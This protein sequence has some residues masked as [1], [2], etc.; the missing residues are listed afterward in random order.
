MTAG[1]Y[2]ELTADEQEIVLA[3][4]GDDYQLDRAAKALHRLTMLARPTREPAGML[5]LPCSWAAV[6][7]L[8]FTFSSDS[9]GRWLPQARLRAWITAE[10]LRR[11]QSRAYPADVLIPAGL[12][13]RPYQYEAASMI[14]AAGKFLLF[15]DP[16]PQPLSARV[17][18][19]S[20]WT[21][22]GAI[23]P[24]DEVIGTDGLPHHV[25]K[26]YDKGVRPVYEI[27]FSDGA[28]TRASADHNWAVRTYQMQAGTSDKH[29]VNNRA[30]EYRLS[31]GQRWLVKKTSELKSSGSLVNFIPVASPV[32]FAKQELP[33]H[34]YVLGALLGNG[35]LSHGVPKDGLVQFTTSREEFA[36][37]VG[38][39]TEIRK[40]GNGLQWGVHA[41]KEVHALGLAGK[42]SREKFIPDSYL[43]G[44]REQREDL[45]N[46]LMD[47]DG[48]V[49]VRPGRRTRLQW[50]TTSP[51]LRNQFT[52][53]VRSLGGTARVMHEDERKASTCWTLSLELPPEVRPFQVSYKA[54]PA[55][56]ARTEPAR[57]VHS[58]EPA[59]SE[60][61]KCLL[62]DAPDHLYITDNYVVTSNCGKTVSTLLGLKARQLTH[63]LFPMLI[64]VPSWDVGDVW[65]R[66]IKEWAPD[67]PEP[68]MYGGSNRSLFDLSGINI[69]TYAT[70][71]IDAAD[72]RGPLVKLKPKAVVL[73]EAHYCRNEKALRTH[74]V[75]RVAAH[76]GTFVG[77]T[78]TPVTKDTGDIYP[79]LAAMDP[80]SYPA[81]KRFVDRY[82]DTSTNGYEESIDGLKALAEPEFRT[83]LQGQYRRVAKADVLPQLPPKIYSVR[84]VELPAEWQRAYDSMEQDMLAEL[85]GDGGQLPVMS[86]LAQLTRLGQL[87]SSACDV[88]VRT[89]LDEYGAE[90]KHYDVTLKAP[91]WKADAL[92][93]VLAERK[94]QQVA[95]FANS[96][97]LVMIAEQACAKAG[98]SCGLI[99]GGQPK[100]AR[101][102]DIGQ[103]QAGE[104]D[105]ILATAGAGALGITLTAA[106]TAVMLQ[107][108]WEFDKALQPEDRLSRLDD[109]V[110]KHDCL[111]IIDIVAKGTIDQRVRELTRSKGMQLGQLVQD[112]RLVRELLGGL[113]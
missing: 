31:R 76:A 30:H 39:Y 40:R 83:V 56:S 2:A 70:L 16:G 48:R 24:G 23:Q 14:A 6:T 41:G 8:A 62:V 111:E 58:V 88:A 75:Q 11:H 35:G 52:E 55:Q 95:V 69:T 21:T 33:L 46:G 15:D 113:K 80:A 99:T 87:A 51:V 85:P 47:S 109:I 27:T 92:L 91:S 86:V 5:T 12:T 107:R 81:R 3:V 68:S 13:P 78:G 71:R 73:D 57:A 97:Q 101:Q 59:G 102:Q 66:H 96:K 1:I 49:S 67:W 94:G 28:R 72:A 105:V 61:V 17:L 53:L 54:G 20:G 7:Q 19:P 29:Q 110:L 25:L 108:S 36:G 43:R 37:L 89:E 38:L 82:L 4:T 93:G 10:F 34:P 9:V 26:T 60:H 112:P 42:K 50:S 64:V 104:L 77:L 100:K 32:E 45:L 106:G 84:R 98:Y 90:T 103:F 65:A 74:A 22:M 63:E 44:S 18:T 79:V